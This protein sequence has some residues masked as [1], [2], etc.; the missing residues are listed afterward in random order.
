MYTE[1]MYSIIA[2]IKRTALRRVPRQNFA[3]LGP[4]IVNLWGGNGL[5]SGQT[6]EWVGGAYCG[7]TGMLRVWI[8]ELY[9]HGMAIAWIDPSSSMDPNSFA[10][11]SESRF[12]M[13]RPPSTEEAL[14]CLEMIIR[15]GCFDVVVIEHSTDVQWNCVRRVQRLAKIHQVI[16]VCFR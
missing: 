3:A 6:V 13:V 15:A 8:E 11:M 14:I 9:Q 4:S 7:K 5:L 12:W 2:D 10:N 1:H 16:L